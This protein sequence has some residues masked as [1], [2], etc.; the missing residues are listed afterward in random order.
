VN[1]PLI[2]FT[3]VTSQA[4]VT[5]LQ[6][7]QPYQ[8]FVG[9]QSQR[10][11]GWSTYNS[12]AFQVSR[13]VTNSLLVDAHYT[14]SKALDYAD[15][16]N[17]TGDYN[18]TGGGTQGKTFNLRSFKQN[19]SPSYFDVPHRLVLSL[20]YDL[21]F[22]PGRQFA[23]HNAVARAVASGWVISTVGTLQSGSP[24][25]ISGDTTGSL[26][27]LPDRAS[28]VPVEVPKNLQHWYNGTTTVTLP[29]GARITPCNLC[30]LKYN[31][32]AFLGQTV[33]TPSGSVVADN[34][35]WGTAAPTFEDIRGNGLDN[36][37][38]TISRTFR[39]KENAS[40]QLS[41]QFTNALNHTEFKPGYTMTL[42]NQNIQ[43]TNPTN[44]TLG[45]GTNN[46]YGTMG[47]TTFDPRQI[48][49]VLKVKF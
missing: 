2:P 8:L 15:N 13:R 44:L 43:P 34:Y 30:F 9:L 38:L 19:Y 48:E 16:E 7:L 22:G 29:N 37:N 1:G 45:Q 35:W 25:L 24:L 23:L 10:T 27:G 41:A 31:S 3:G 33:S 11:L 26:N 39:I 20:V 4:T 49:M 47:T 28:G 6:A 40:I 14:W 17:L 36:W 12:L 18:D 46:Y 21:P 5:A 42:G 32:A